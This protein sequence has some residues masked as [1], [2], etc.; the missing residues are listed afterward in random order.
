MRWGWF[1][2][3]GGLVLWLAGLGTATAGDGEEQW[4]QEAGIIHEAISEKEWGQARRQLQALAD[5]WFTSSLRTGWEQRDIVVVSNCIVELDRALDPSSPQPQ[6]ALERAEQLWLA[7]DARIHPQQPLWHEYEEVF[8]QDLD[9]LKQALQQGEVKEFETTMTEWRHHLEQIRPALSITFSAE[10]VQQ[11]EERMEVPN[12][13]SPSDAKALDQ[14]IK[15]W[16]ALVPVLFGGTEAEIERHLAG[17][18]SP[19]GWPLALLMSVIG[20]VLGYV[21]YLKYRYEQ[22]PHPVKSYRR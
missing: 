11:L 6:K 5:E 4:S 21:A 19:L 13:S 12:N 8:Q 20:T 14:H 3:C 10:T 22:R 1:L 2:L 7:L 16:E 18:P 15:E 17:V 9:E